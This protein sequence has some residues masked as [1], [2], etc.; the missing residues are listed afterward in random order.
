MLPARAPATALAV[1]V[2]EIASDGM[3]VAPARLTAPL[4]PLML[5]AWAGVRQAS[6]AKPEPPAPGLAVLKML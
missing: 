1:L 3:P 2:D 6:A 4:P 5:R